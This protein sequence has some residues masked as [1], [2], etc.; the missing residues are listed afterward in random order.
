[1]GSINNIFVIIV[2]A[3]VVY[4]SN[5]IYLGQDFLTFGTRYV[6]VQMIATNKVRTAVPI[7]IVPPPK[8]SKIT[9]TETGV[10]YPVCSK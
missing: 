8:G 3:S 2:M 7:W 5:A 10:S 1:M 6:K 9:V 4:G